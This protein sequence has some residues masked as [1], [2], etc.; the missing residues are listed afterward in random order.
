MKH[1]QY[2]IKVELTGDEGEGTSDYVSYQ[3]SHK[4]S[5]KAKYGDIIASSNRSLLGDR[6]KYN[7]EELLIASIAA[8]HMLCYLQLCAEYDIVVTGYTD[9]ATGRL[10]RSNDGSGSI[11]SVTLNPIVVLENE[12]VLGLATSIHEK[13]SRMSFIANS[14]NFHVEH[15]PVMT[16]KCKPLN[17]SLKM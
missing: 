7:P 11:C 15:N 13:A 17:R 4:I 1:Q 10:I 16:V 12:K 2:D 3:R 6:S 14:C 8:C 5:A 9:N